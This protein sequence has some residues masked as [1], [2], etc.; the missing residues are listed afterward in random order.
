MSF[1]ILIGFSFI[2]ELKESSGLHFPVLR[3]LSIT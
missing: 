1:D 3:V 2:G